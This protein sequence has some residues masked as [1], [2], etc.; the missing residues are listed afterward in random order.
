MDMVTF[1][2]LFSKRTVQLPILIFSI[3]ILFSCSAIRKAQHIN[4]DN[5]SCLPIKAP[6]SIGLSTIK[7]IHELNI[8]TA[9]SSRFSF[10][11]LNVANSIGILEML[12]QYVALNEKV[13]QSASFENRLALLEL[14]HN[15]SKRI[16][17]AS[18]E[19]SSVTSEIDCEE[20]K[21]AQIADYLSK[22]EQD[23]ETKLTVVAIVVS[24]ADAI[25]S[26][27]PKSVF[28]FEYMGLVSGITGTTIAILILKNQQKVVLKHNRNMLHEIW[29]GN[30][31]S[32]M[33]PDFIW[34]YL[35]YYD[36]NK[37]NERSI[38]YQIVERWMNFKQI[39]NANAKKRK[40]LI[41]IYFG[42]GGE[43]S[44]DQ[45]YNRANMYDQL[46]SYIKLIKQE[47]TLLAFEFEN[48]K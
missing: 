13:K 19:V 6:V 42:N 45:L 40:V 9:L 10:T 12:G 38:R 26:T 5:T 30:E 31:Q 27:L 8:D 43:Y 47:L 36:P 23:K 4:M 17:Q 35:N 33:F 20:E 21:I 29:V 18:L 3:G 25:L 7:P 16:S 44:T 28:N 22:K 48:I 39:D 2:F 41:D 14:S 32:T 11:S 15:I 37:K 1:T 24:A 46:E 34:Y